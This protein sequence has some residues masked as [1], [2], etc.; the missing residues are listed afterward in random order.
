MIYFPGEMG[1]S[2]YFTGMPYLMIPESEHQAAQES[3]TSL[4][5]P[6]SAPVE[7]QR[8]VKKRFCSLGL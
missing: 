8:A 3:L 2:I 6:L 5:P 4:R 1:Q 7:R